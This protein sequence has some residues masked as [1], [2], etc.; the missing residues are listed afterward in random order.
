MSLHQ[1]VPLALHLQGSLP[2]LVAMSLVSPVFAFVV[3]QQKAIFGLL[4]N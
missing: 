1:I 4:D 2:S 3:E